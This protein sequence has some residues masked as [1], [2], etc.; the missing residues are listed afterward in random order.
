[1]KLKILIPVIIFLSACSAKYQSPVSNE[2]TANIR[3]V[4]SEVN[5]N[6]YQIKNSNCR[7]RLHIGTLKN[8]LI[9]SS[10]E[11]SSIGMPWETNRT[12][13]PAPRDFRE[14]VVPAGEAFYLFYNILTAGYSYTVNTVFTPEAG[15]SYEFVLDTN[16]F[17]A[18]KLIVTDGRVTSVE[19][20]TTKPKQTCAD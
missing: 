19:F 9:S 20:L 8:A 14:I 17:D 3:F 11:E 10:E 5:T 15:A 18:K 1:M 16:D 6:I 2:N 4:A 12:T 7:D 13:K